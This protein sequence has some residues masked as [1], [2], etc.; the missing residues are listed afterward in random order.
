MALKRNLVANYLGQGWA[1]L[2][3]LLFIPVYID[4]LGM[5]AFA[6]VGVYAVLQAWLTL[7][8][9]GMSTTLNREM[10]RFT[11][12]AHTPQSIRDLL[13]SLEWMGVCVAFLIGGSIW[14]ISAWLARDWLR[15]DMLPSE[16]ISQAIAIMGWVVAGRLV[17]GLYRGVLLGL[18]RQVLF[19]VVNAFFATLRAAGAIAVLAWVSP[20]IEAYFVW[21]L[22][23]SLLALAFL[24]TVAHVCLPAPP[25]PERFS[26]GAIRSVWRFAAGMA[27]T[28]F[29]A[30]MLTQVDKV[31]LS[32]L[33]NL[34]DFGYYAL[35]TTVA[36]GLALLVNPI[37]QAYYPRFSESV[38]R[39]DSAGLTDDYHRGAQLVSVLVA[40]VAMMLIFYG[41]NIMTLWT[42]DAALSHRVAPLLTLLALGTLLNGM[43]HIPY[44]LQLAHGWPGLAVRVNLVAVIVLV[45]TILWVTPRYGAIGAASVWVLLNTAYV[46]I[47]VHFMY[48]RLLIEEKWKWYRNDILW[49][50]GAGAV[51][52]VVSSYLQPNSDGLLLQWGWIVMAGLLTLV[53]S[54]VASDKM[55]ARIFRIYSVHD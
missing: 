29:L 16:T 54:L 40:P 51:I 32:R 38:A 41:Q 7:L 10:A 26:W 47:G 31:L 30:L 49:P 55:W 17:E 48:R 18:Q 21:Q 11:A 36:S 8:D 33:L 6:L 37:S 46:M 35:A 3:G 45:P 22:V 1:G 5:E 20:T 24:G 25:S 28:T 13:R 14:S 39:G 42:G 2:M 23:V 12:G 4:Y 44:M 27:A 50:V 9:M 15:A 43:M 19:N 34:E 53:A 52:A